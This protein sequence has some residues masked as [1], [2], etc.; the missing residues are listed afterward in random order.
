MTKAVD[1]Y[2]LATQCAGWRG[3]R[4]APEE[5]NICFTGSY[6]G[7]ALRLQSWRQFPRSR[8]CLACA[9][10]RRPFRTLS[11]T[12][13]IERRSSFD[14]ESMLLDDTVIEDDLAL[15]R[16]ENDL[17]KELNSELKEKIICCCQLLGDIA[18]PIKKLQTNKS[19]DVT[20]KCKNKEDVERTTAMLRNKL[21]NDYQVE[22]QTLKAPR[23]RILDVQNDMNLES[24][25]EDIKNR[26]PVML[27]ES[28]P[29]ALLSHAVRQSPPDSV[30]LIG[31]YAVA[32]MQRAVL[33]VCACA[34][35]LCVS[36]ER[37]CELSPEGVEAAPKSPGDNHYRLVV[38]GDIERYLPEQRYVVTLVG[39]R[40]HDVV[41]QFTKF[42]VTLEPLDPATERTPRRQGQFQ[43]FADTLTVFHE[44]CMNTVTQADDLPK[45]EVQVM[46]KA[47]PAGSG[48][49]LIKAMIMES[50]ERW[51]AED[52]QLTRRVCEDTSASAPG[53]CACDDARYKM[54][55]E[56]LWSAQ[57]HPKD[58]PVNTLWLTHF[59]DVIGATH[60]RNFS[61]W[62]EG[63]IATDGF[64]FT[65]DIYQAAIFRDLGL[66]LAMASMLRAGI[67][68]PSLKGVCHKISTEAGK[69]RLCTSCYGRFYSFY[70]C[71]L[72]WTKPWKGQVPSVALDAE[73]AS[74]AVC[75]HTAARDGERSL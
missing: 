40:T 59:S 60:S 14:T 23:M 56:G 2:P 71:T 18:V 57:T 10:A 74:D 46:W 4:H 8:R 63:Q 21:I 1:V 66:F 27:N 55:F 69:R 17:L 15:L 67:R 33:T 7:G 34:V 45:T 13:S 19:G 35:W 41:Q 36:G 49:V 75:F 70:L 31:A 11:D 50:P 26:N 65:S 51:F 24:L 52:G 43:L 58:F 9:R 61:F 38:N 48:C 28:A 72:R 25:T 3:R 62:G 20:I 29:S 30:E 32:R 22:V 12:K 42:K 37:A 47:P 64:R 44:E 53:C 16:V 73:V 5:M 39:A 68:S 6:N 54:V